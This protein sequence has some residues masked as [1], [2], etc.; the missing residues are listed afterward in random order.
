MMVLLY[1]MSQTRKHSL[2]YFLAAD[3]AVWAQRENDTVLDDPSTLSMLS[4]MP[5]TRKRSFPNFLPRGSTASAQ[6]DNAAESVNEHQLQPHPKH[7]MKRTTPTASNVSPAEGS[8]P[9][10]CSDIVAVT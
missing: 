2:L 3:S 7:D 4:A 10:F 9:A 1:A 8:F 5:P 6:H